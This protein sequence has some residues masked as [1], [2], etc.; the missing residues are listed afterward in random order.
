LVQQKVNWI[1]EQSTGNLYTGE[2]KFVET[3]YA[4]HGDGKNNPE[5]EK[6]KSVGPLPQGYYMAGWMLDDKHT[7]LGS[8]WLYPH[9]HNEMYGRGDFR[10]HGDN[11]RGDFSASE[12]CIIMSWGVRKGI[13]P[14]HVIQ[15]VATYQTPSSTQQPT[16]STA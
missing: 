6:V 13:L 15:V 9:P 11:K 7:G 10:V 8:V 12:G 16:P 3:G 14:G 4:G 5:K 1:Y 2:G